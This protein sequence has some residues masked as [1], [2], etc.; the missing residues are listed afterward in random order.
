MNGISSHVGW[1]RA[2]GLT[3]PFVQLVARR[4]G[5]GLRVIR[6]KLFFVIRRAAFAQIGR[7]VPAD[8]GA[9]PFAAARALM[10]MRFGLFDRNGEG[11]VVSLAADGAL[12]LISALPRASQNASED[13]SGGAKHI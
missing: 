11:V 6:S 8:V 5:F 2:I 13:V 4:V 10:K 12:D 3:R 9:D 1:R 7:G